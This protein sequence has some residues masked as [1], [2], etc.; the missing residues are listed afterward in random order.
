MNRNFTLIRARTY[1]LTATATNGASA[2]N[3]T[4]STLTLKAR[5]SVDG[6]EVFSCSSP[7]DGITITSA[8][9]GQFTVTISTSKTTSLPVQDGFL[10]LPYEL[11]LTTASNEVYTI[12]YGKLI[13][14]PNIV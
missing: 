6:D 2:V 7:S 13:V 4:G 3:L 1:V 11:I 10:S 9:N 5:W 14:K 12:L 8:A